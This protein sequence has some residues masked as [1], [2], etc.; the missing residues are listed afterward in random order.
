[1]LLRTNA[2][3]RKATK[4]TAKFLLS[5]LTLAPH[6][7]SGHNVCPGSSEGCRDSCN[8][9]FSGLRV[10]P[11]ARFA[12]IA[13]TLW[14]VNERES[15]FAQLN[16]DIGNQLRRA[17]KSRMV[18]L[19]RLNMASDLDWTELI[20]KW[21]AV[22]FFDYT[23][24]RSRF[25]K[26]LNGGL[27]QNY[28]LTFSRHEKHSEGLLAS[29]LSRGGNITQVYDVAYNGARGTFGPLPE[30]EEVGGLRV[31]VIDGD[32]HDV[33]LPQID[34]SGVIVGLRVKGTNSAKLAA[35][36]SGFAR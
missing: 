27:P 3:L 13:Q 30:F 14:L 8:M 9:L 34:G 31:P 28:H 23:K 4:Q 17:E 1:M 22:Q 5:G 16:R 19:I 33:R 10:T 6:S 12:A 21:P 29:F 26:Y 15:F 35:R 25:E 7:V 11:Q 2:K 24:I 18:P 36:E 32:K 20:E